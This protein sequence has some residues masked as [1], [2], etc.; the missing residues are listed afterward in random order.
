MKILL[1]STSFQDTPGKHQE[2]LNA[3]GFEIDYLRG[4]V[5]EAVLLPI[6]NEYD[7]VICGDD[8]YTEQVLRKGRAG[9]LKY[10]S[11]YGVGLD[12][13]NLKIAEEL[14][15]PVKNCPGVNQISVAEHVLALILTFEKNIHIQHPSVQSGSWKR[16]TGHEIEGKTIGIIGLGAIGKALAKKSIA[17]GLNVIAFDLHKDPQFL[18]ANPEVYFA[19]SIQN[20]FNESD[21]ISLHL[22]HTPQTEYIINESII[23]TQLTKKPVIINT[24]RGMLVDTDAII[25]GLNDGKIRGYL[26]DV[27]AVEPID[28][29]E[30]LLGLQNVIITPH[31]GS[32]TYESVERQGMMAVQNLLSLING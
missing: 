9:K 19:E 27:L 25:S 31:V 12:K 14:G 23:N 18:T 15:I 10:I 30:K 17:L 1:T 32:R 24:A 29:N 20:L 3:Q 11:K 21:Y 7:A 8:E 28:K 26:T 6:I 13:I 4:P 2:L 16:Y 5:T 22:P